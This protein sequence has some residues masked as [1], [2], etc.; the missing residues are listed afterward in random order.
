[1]FF[2]CLFSDFVGTD[3]GIPE[4]EPFDLG[5]GDLL[6]GDLGCAF[7]QR[8]DPGAG[9]WQLGLEDSALRKLDRDLRAP[10]GRR[11][12]TYRNCKAFI[13]A[14]FMPFKDEIPIEILP[15]DRDG[16]VGDHAGVL[17]CFSPRS[18]HPC[19]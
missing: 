7:A 16:L 19:G 18:C 14:S 10:A 15:C 13:H 9:A 2:A 6:L 1:M 12:F 4:Q 3:V 5:I 11:A 8:L 17:I